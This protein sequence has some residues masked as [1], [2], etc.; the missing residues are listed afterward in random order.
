MFLKTSFEERYGQFSPDG[1][2]V[3]YE[4]NESGRNEIYIRPFATAAAGNVPANSAA[5]QWQVSAAGGIHPR[6]RPDGT[7]VYYIGPGGEMMA[8]PIPTSGA[9]LVPGTPVTL[10]PTRIVNG[11]VDTNG[12]AEATVRRRASVTI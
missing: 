5:G 9:T 4:S 8:T 10:F 2:W 12:A 11:G 6:W 1:R 7:E 3:A